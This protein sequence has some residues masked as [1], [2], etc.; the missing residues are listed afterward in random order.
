M[1]ATLVLGTSAERRASSSLALGI[2]IILKTLVFIG[3]INKCRGFINLFKTYFIDQKLW[4]F[5]L[6]FFC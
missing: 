2:N 5:Y 1:A 4:L 6:R 3:N